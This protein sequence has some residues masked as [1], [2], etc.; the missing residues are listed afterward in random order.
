I[1][2]TRFSLDDIAPLKDRRKGKQAEHAGLTDEESAF[3]QQAES[4]QQYI[5]VLQDDIFS[6][7]IQLAL[8]TDMG[9]LVTLRVI[10][11]AES[12]DHVYASALAEGRVLPPK[13]NLQR[14]LEDRYF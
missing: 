9:I 8:D 5:S 7:S 3:E 6:K 14:A 2:V 1:L 12:D 11:R 10:E 4:L 13:S